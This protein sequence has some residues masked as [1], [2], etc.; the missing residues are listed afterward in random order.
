MSEIVF[1]ALLTAD[2]AIEEKNGKK[3][4]IGIFN[5]FNIRDA[6]KL[7]PPWV[8]FASITNLEGKH[9]FNLNL[10]RDESPDVVL[11]VGGQLEAEDRR[12][13]IDLIIPIIGT[14]FPREGLYNLVLTVDDVQVGTRVIHVNMVPPKTA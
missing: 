5:T 14:V 8:V 10:I 1:Q 13:N 2:K 7:S 12:A 6:S 9:E 11:S 4:L 3:G